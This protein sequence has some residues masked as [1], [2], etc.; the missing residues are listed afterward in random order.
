MI[1]IKSM[2]QIMTSALVPGLQS[3]QTLERSDRR[4]LDYGRID[5]AQLQAA[6][7]DLYRQWHNQMYRSRRN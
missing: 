1:R 2:K 5:K 4:W 3:L 7:S 6:A